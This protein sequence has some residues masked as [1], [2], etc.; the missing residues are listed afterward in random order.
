MVYDHYYLNNNHTSQ[1]SNARLLYTGIVKDNPQWF[2]VPHSHDFFELLFVIQGSGNIKIDGGIFMVT[3]GDLLLI[4]PHVIHEEESDN[5]NP[6]YLAF[7]GVDNFTIDDMEENCFLHPLSSPIVKLNQ[8]RSKIQNLILELIHETSHQIKFHEE[9]SNSILSTLIVT[10]QRIL[11][12]DVEETTGN[13]KKIKEFI[14][15]NYHENMSLDSLSK[16]L[17]VSKH[18]L[19]HM[20]KNEFGTSPIKYLIQKRMLAAKELL[21]TTDK[22]IADIAVCVGYDDVTYFSQI[23][24]KFTGYSPRAY[25]KT[26]R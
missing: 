21:E 2:N 3:Q 13:C 22:S 17:Y 24:K 19:S 23:F 26:F 11:L 25:R 9:M 12:S 18:H 20:F 8:H 4:N 14:D 7:L 15:Y 1:I 6:I 5:Q 16:T 10:I